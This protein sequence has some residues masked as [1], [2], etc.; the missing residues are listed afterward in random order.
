MTKLNENTCLWVLTYDVFGP[1]YSCS[2][3]PPFVPGRTGVGLAP[4]DVRNLLTR[5]QCLR[6]SYRDNGD[7]VQR[8]TH[9]R[10]QFSIFSVLHIFKFYI[11]FDKNTFVIITS[12]DK[13][14]VVFSSILK[15]LP[16][17]ASTKSLYPIIL[18]KALTVDSLC[19]TC[20]QIINFDWHQ[21][22]K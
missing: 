10:F 3:C 17:K 4:P 7:V 14:W 13:S 18:V 22:F 6:L 9:S 15:N 16:H 5:P 21:V 11:P 8:H 20:Y 1:C 2:K 19:T 12:F